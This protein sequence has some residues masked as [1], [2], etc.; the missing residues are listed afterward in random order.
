[1]SEQLT[2]LALLFI[3]GGPKVPKNPQLA[4]QLALQGAEKQCPFAFYILGLFYLYGYE[5]VEP[6]IRKSIGYLRKAA[7]KDC[8]DAQYLLGNLYSNGQFLPK[9]ECCATRFYK[10]AAKQGH[11]KACMKLGKLYLENDPESSLDIIQKRLLKAYHFYEIA[12][13]SGSK[14]SKKHLI[15]LQKVLSLL[16]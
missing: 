6:D 15:E 4:F 1:M 10:N 3:I 5:V 11:S 2:T 16:E 14:R 13:N 8:S 12:A 7:E 9:N